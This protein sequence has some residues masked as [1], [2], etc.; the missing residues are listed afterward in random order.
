[1]R[2]AYRECCTG[3]NGSFLRPV[4][5]SKK[6]GGKFV[7][8]LALPAK[9]QLVSCKSWMGPNILGAHDLQ[10]WRGRATRGRDPWGG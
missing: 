5:N 9:R 10:S 7:R 8:L 2:R 4:E 1:M 3:W 6:V